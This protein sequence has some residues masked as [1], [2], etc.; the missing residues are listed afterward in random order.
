MAAKTLLEI[1]KEKEMKV[2]AAQKRRYPHFDPFINFSRNESS[3]TSFLSNPTKVQEHSFYPFIKASILTPRYKNTGKKDANG[4]WIRLLE[5]KDRPILFASHFDAYIYSWYSTL[6]TE[7]YERKIKSNNWDVYDNVLAYIEKGKSN[8]EFAD[9]AFKYI[10]NKGNCVALAY[11][12]KSFFDRLDHAHLERMWRIVIN[13]SCLPKDHLNVYKSLTKYAFVEMADLEKQFPLFFKQLEKNRKIKA[14]KK[15][16]P[17]HR[18]CTP[19]EFRNKVRA[20]KLIRENLFKN[21]NAKSTRYGNKCGI[22]QGSP[23]SA[24]LSNIYMIEFDIALK[25]L[26][27]AIGGKYWRYCDDILF[28]SDI[29]FET[30]VNDTINEEI[31]KCHLEINTDKTEII[32]FKVNTLGQLKAFDKNGIPSTLQ[33]L[34]FEFNGQNICIRSSSISKYHRRMTARI[35]EN[36]KSAYGHNSIGKKVFK[37]KLLNRYSIKG[38]RNFIS[39]AKRASEIMQ[40]PTIKK[41]YKNSINKVLQKFNK[42][43]AAFEKKRGIKKIKG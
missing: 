14:K 4:K 18:I 37:R 10:Q 23:I 36:L 41:Q 30:Q 7:K 13:K 17:T 8:I 6:L 32:I 28:I 26:A 38:Q 9:E 34:G 16:H 42:K 24:C 21:D 5:V 25:K 19:E 15:K 2:L 20:N 39:Y 35:R 22:P 40:S 33:Y 11:D 3:L 12:V 43:K 27:T 31:A 29:S 1:W